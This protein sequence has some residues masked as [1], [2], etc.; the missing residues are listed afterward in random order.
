[1]NTAEII[2]IA[3]EQAVKLPAAFHFD[4]EV[5]SIRREGNAV[6]LEPVE[7]AQSVP[8]VW[9]EGFFESIRIDDPSFVRPGQGEMPPAPGLD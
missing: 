6:I 8:D 7:S 3:G 9:P 4:S 1:V 2:D 5:V